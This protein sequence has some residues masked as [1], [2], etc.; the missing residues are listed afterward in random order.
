MSI[1]SDTMSKAIADYRFLLR[2]YLTQ[3][4]RMAILHQLKLKDSDTYESDVALFE[5]GRAIVANIEANM[6]MT[7]QG[8][9]SY[10][11]IQQFC[12]YLKEYLDNYFIDEKNQVVHRAQKASRALIQA[13]QLSALPQERLNDRIAKQLLECNV[14]VIDFGSEEQWEMQRQTLVRQKDN[15]PAFYAHVIAHL[16]SLM[17]SDSAQAA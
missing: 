1:F 10:S 11:G 6:A 15:H 9:Y 2:R 13:I 3:S 17:R 8:Y 14:A 7:N 4:D 12:E 16:D 5:V